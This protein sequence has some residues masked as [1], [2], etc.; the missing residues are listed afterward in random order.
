MLKRLPKE[1]LENMGKK[2]KA[3]QLM[4]RVVRKAIGRKTETLGY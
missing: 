1:K 3:I 2:V 4:R